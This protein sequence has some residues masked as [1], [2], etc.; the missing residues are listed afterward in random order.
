MSKS[1]VLVIEDNREIRLSARFVLEDF[2]FVI[3]E[4]ESPAQAKDW[5]ARQ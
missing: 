2:G 3:A 5:L 1:T 4:A